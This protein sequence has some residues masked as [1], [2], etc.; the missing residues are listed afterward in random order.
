MCYNFVWFFDELICVW[1]A[2]IT[3]AFFELNIFIYIF[4]CGTNYILC[5]KGGV[6]EI[7]FCSL[8]ALFFM[9][10]ANLNL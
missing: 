5:I 9:L 7:T 10:G 4:T 1:R 8:R 3:D 2:Y 6:Q